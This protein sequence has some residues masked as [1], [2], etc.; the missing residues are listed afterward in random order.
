MMR[1]EILAF[2]RRIWAVLRA[3]AKWVWKMITFEPPAPTW[4]DVFASCWAQ[5]VRVPDDLFFSVLDP[6]SGVQRLLWPCLIGY[7]PTYGDS[8]VFRL[9]V[10]PAR[11]TVRQIINALPMIESGMEHKI[12]KAEPVAGD[13]NA[14][15]ISAGT[16][17]SFETLLIPEQMRI[18][19]PSDSNWRVYMGWNV[20]G[21]EV[22]LDP[23]NKSALLLTGEPGSGKSLLLQRL[24]RSWKKSDAI[25]HIADFKLSGDFDDLGAD[26]CPVLG[27]DVDSVIAMLE[28]AR[29]VIDG[30]IS[31]MAKFRQPNYWNY[32]PDTRPPLYVIA[33]DE[34]QEL[35]ETSGVTK[36]QKQKAE[37]AAALLRS[38][39]K[40]GR[41][42]GVF[43][44]L[45]TQK[46]DATAIP[47]N[48][49]D[50]MGLRISGR[51]FTPEASK[52]ALGSVPDGFRPDD[53]D[54]VPANTPGRM[55]MVGQGAPFVFQCAG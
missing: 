39:V 15:D 40:L 7:G 33:I 28:K 51:Q 35:L 16:P 24:L 45:S 53:T 44:V 18:C 32:S 6:I 43:V 26:E 17:P 49:R 38:L 9:R 11:Q 34:V 21:E 47:T 5:G 10:W 23:H 30:R 41:S 1:D 36:E 20:L 29:D 37:H 50:Q 48:L 22:H 25:V 42:A 27:G 46:S 55:V 12:W 4:A 14:I 19:R 54:V 13:V 31:Q 3:F 2:V 52:A 8:Y